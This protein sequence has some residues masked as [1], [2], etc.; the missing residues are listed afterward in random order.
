MLDLAIR[1]GYQAPLV[2]HNSGQLLSEIPSTQIVPTPPPIS[3]WRDSL[4]P[5]EPSGLK[6]DATQHAL[7]TDKQTLQP[8]RTP[9]TRVVEIVRTDKPPS[10]NVPDEN[11]PDLYSVNL[12]S[13]YLMPTRKSSAITLLSLLFSYVS[14]FGLYRYLDPGHGRPSAEDLEEKKWIATSHSWADRT[15]CRLFGICGATHWRSRIR[16][17]DF[18]E[19]QNQD[20]VDNADRLYD[21]WNEGKSDPKQWTNDERVLREIPQY[22]FEYAPLVHLFSDEQF[23]PCDIAEHLLHVTPELDYTPIQE[24]SPN[25]TNLDQLNEWNRG[26]S[27]Y[28]TSD[29]DPEQKPDWLSG[30]KNIPALPGEDKELREDPIEWV[31]KQTQT[32]GQLRNEEAVQEGWYEAGKGGPLQKRGNS[33]ESYRPT[34]ERN[35]V[36]LRSFRGLPNP[37]TKGGRSDAP[38]VLVVV[39]KG[40]G[41][42]DAFW[43]YFYSFNLG[44]V[45]LN[46]RFGNHVGDWEHSLVRFQHGKPKAVFFSEHNFGEAYSYD[47]VEKIG[48]RVSLENLSQ[49]V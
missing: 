28:L 29:D 33:R 10:V 6:L 48:K 45:V 38:A 39:D 14:F 8:E 42:I 31:E 25:L 4:Q 47:A 20:S 17:G 40:D 15:A 46:V 9:S 30:E 22:V 34:R 7:G 37:H 5:Q 26:R 36:R 23:W 43:F 16:I 19:T 18:A 3:P 21:I 27:V 35:N 13:S 11:L 44:N 41:I 12:T 1:H 32:T 49:L 2:L 24:R